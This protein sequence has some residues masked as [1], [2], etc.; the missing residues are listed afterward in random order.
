MTGIA[1]AL[2]RV[3]PTD[4]LL[5]ALLPAERALLGGAATPK[6]RAELTAGRIAARAALGRLIG[7]EGAGAAILRDDAGGTA[8]PVAISARGAR[9]PVHVS[10][11]HADGL[12]AAAAA[13]EPIGVDLVALEPLGEA[14]AEE[15]FSADE[16][17]AW[18]RWLGDARGSPRAACVAFAAK[19]AAS[20]WLATGLTVPLRAIAVAPA[21][22]GRAAW[23]GRIRTL[24]APLEIA[25]PG[26]L[27]RV[28]GWLAISPRRVLVAAAGTG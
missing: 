23:L 20:K 6:R 14:F 16:L 1:V 13:T 28:A 24:A 15:A 21:G 12:A 27:A 4:R 8:R 11:T 3:H 22:S 25:T 18:E 2:R 17:A 9:L 10:I 19:E 26:R 5:A 7:P